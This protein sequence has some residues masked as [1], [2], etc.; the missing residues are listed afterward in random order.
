MDD[1]FLIAT[2]GKIKHALSVFNLYNENLHFTVEYKD[3]NRSISL[4]DME[5]NTI[6]NKVIT[7][8]YMKLT[9]S[10]K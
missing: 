6:N 4:L 1:S 7:D 9:A 2:S 8:W 10:G 3:N 5:I